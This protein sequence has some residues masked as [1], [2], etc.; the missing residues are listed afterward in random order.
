MIRDRIV[1]QQAGNGN[2]VG[3]RVDRL[4]LERLER[5]HVLEDFCEVVDEFIFFRR[6]ERQ[7]RK[8]G[9][10]LYFFPRDGHGQ[11]LSLSLGKR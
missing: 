10:P 5:L 7:T 8:R 6:G 11:V 9:C 3:S 2:G 1:P 4:G